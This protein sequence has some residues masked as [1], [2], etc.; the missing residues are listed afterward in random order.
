M[1]VRK[2]IP[3]ALL[4]TFLGAHAQPREDTKYYQ[5][6]FCSKVQDSQADY[7]L[8]NGIK[9]DCYVKD[10]LREIELDINGRKKKVI[11]MGLA[12]RYS[13]A[14]KWAECFSQALY[15]SANTTALAVCHLLGTEKELDRFLPRAKKVR[16][17][18]NLEIGF[19]TTI[20]E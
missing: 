16:A 20:I 19:F 18:H 11:K 2:L 13:F 15:Y 7:K 6:A 10:S 14:D 12:I 4:T 1:T 5:D 8:K 3:I 9:I 17:Y